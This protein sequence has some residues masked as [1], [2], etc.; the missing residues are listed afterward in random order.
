[1]WYKTF[2]VWHDI[3]CV[4]QGGSYCMYHGRREEKDGG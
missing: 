2:Y 4:G 1:M 3:F